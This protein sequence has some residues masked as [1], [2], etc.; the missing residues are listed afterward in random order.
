MKILHVIPTLNR[1]AGGTVTAVL[2][3]VAAAP[4][5]QEVVTLDRPDDPWL[6]G[7]SGPIHPLGPG[8]GTY[9]FCPRFIPA[10]RSLARRVQVVV[11]HGLW[12]FHS[13]ATSA[14]LSGGGIPYVVFPHG[15]LDPWFRQT[16]P[17]K[18]LKKSVYWHLRERRVLQGAAAVLF[19]AEEERKGAHAS[20]PF[21]ARAEKIVTLGVLPPPAPPSEAPGVERR[22]LFLGRLD[23]KK[24]CDL[25]LRAFAAELRST[26]WTLTMAGPDSS[27]WR[28]EL[29]F[30]ARE[31]G[32]AAQ[33]E[34]P[35]LMQGDAKWRELRRAQALVIPSHQENFCLSAVEAMG[36]G[37]PVF[38]TQKVN[39][40]REVVASGA[41][42]AEPDD[43]PGIRNLVRRAA[44]L[45]R[46]A[47]AEM[48][49]A[50]QE[51][52]REHYSVA[53]AHASLMEALAPLVQS[54]GRMG[55]APCP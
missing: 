3:M 29:E 47:R 46:E 15:M 9:G 42:V 41:G 55:A 22:L 50:G 35:G 20:F 43:L 10:L 18:H 52:F 39:I 53:R 40:W 16:Y 6:A 14:A 19:T 49:L 5:T 17:W 8:L 24:G 23:P 31:L 1:A 4:D 38:L 51:A 30:L 25:L 33:V 2:G 11:V 34:W 7:L 45:A 48:S 12:Q 28:R 26:S 27:G 37:T 44:Q 54:T 32:I 36:C 21:S 13:V